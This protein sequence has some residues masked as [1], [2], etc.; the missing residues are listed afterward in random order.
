M[1]GWYIWSC[2]VCSI[3]PGFV[4]F[5]LLLVA[6]SNLHLQSEL[7]VSSC[8]CCPYYLLYPYPHLYLHLFVSL[9]VYPHAI[10]TPAMH[11]QLEQAQYQKWQVALAPPFHQGQGATGATG[12]ASIIDLV[13]YRG[14]HRCG[15]VVVVVAVTVAVTVTVQWCGAV[16]WCGAVQWCSV[17][18]CGCGAVAVQCCGVVRSAGVIFGSV[19]RWI[20]M[21]VCNGRSD[22]RPDKWSV[23]GR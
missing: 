14:M 23:G 18:R 8:S 9:C 4:W 20:G 7:Q 1:K 15:A 5:C 2:V 22:G 17:V 13:T 12:A 6:I 19:G 10:S 3:A 11:P 21:L 16:R